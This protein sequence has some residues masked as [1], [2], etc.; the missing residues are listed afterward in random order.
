METEGPKDFWILSLSGGGYRGLF[1]ATILEEMERRLPT[2][3]RLADKFDLIA[4]TSAGSLLAAAIAK[5]VPAT[6]L[7]ETF[8]T[9][10]DDIFDAGLF[11][12]K[13][14]FVLGRL[15]LGIFGAR[16]NSAG[17]QRVLADEALL[18]SATFNSL[19][20]RLL[21]PTVN[22]TKGGA[23]FFKTPHHADYKNDGAVSLVDACMASGAA[24][25]FFP[26]HRFNNSRYTD[27]G[28]V[29]NSPVFVAYHE[30]V[31]KLGVD[32]RRVHIISVG[33]MNRSVTIDT[34]APLSMGLIMASGW[35][36]W[37]GWKARLLEVML[38]A[39]EKLAIDMI[40]HVVPERI[41]ILDDSLDNDQA[42]VIG[43]DKVSKAAKE[44]LAGRADTV[45]RRDLNGPLLEQ[46]LNHQP[47]APVFFNQAD[48]GQHA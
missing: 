46:W 5:R 27:G 39:Q 48:G 11:R 32:P 44:A 1:T 20:H 26:V 6:K 24:P 19:K 8:E 18:G 37:M 38:A 9:R 41:L 23:Q 28:L 15:N 25:T 10:G 42:M 2:G 36:F 12:W 3:Q 30:A 21:I 16:Y 35:R 17:L 29:A 13:R 31:T 14:W 22:L 34:R 33:T 47:E 4:G 7:R 40:Q 43:L 45:I